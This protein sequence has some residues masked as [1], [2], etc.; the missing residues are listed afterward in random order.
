MNGAAIKFPG[1]GPNCRPPGII[2]V[3][4]IG[5]PRFIWAPIKLLVSMKLF[6]GLMGRLK[7]FNFISKEKKGAEGVAKGNG[8]P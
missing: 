4:A 5:V 3:W 6:L 2:I 7:I 8:W 1:A